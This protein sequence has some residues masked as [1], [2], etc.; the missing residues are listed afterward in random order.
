MTWG[1]L[2]GPTAFTW[3][4][5]LCFLALAAMGHLRG[6]F[7]PSVSFGPGVGMGALMLSLILD[8]LLAQSATLMFA[9]ILLRKSQSKN[10]I[11]SAVCQAMGLLVYFLISGLD[12]RIAG[13]NALFGTTGGTLLLVDWYGVTIDAIS[14]AVLSKLFF[15]SAAILGCYRLMREELQL[16]NRPWAWVAFLALLCGYIYGLLLPKCESC[17][18]SP[19]VILLISAVIFGVGAYAALFADRKAAQ[20]LGRFFTALLGRP[21]AAF[22]K[23]PL[24]LPVLLVAVAL[25]A[26]SAL[27]GLDD[28]VYLDGDP[29][30]LGGMVNDASRTF[31]LATLFLVLRDFGLV[32]GL[33]FGR[34]GARADLMALFW[35]A[36]LHL[37]LPSV[38]QVLGATF[39]A[40]MFSPGIT[41]LSGEG[42]IGAAA[43]ALLGTV[44]A[45]WRWRS[46]QIRFQ[47]SLPSGVSI[48]GK[49]T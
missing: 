46:S 21:F 36:I 4:A 39:L 41:A 34:K 2:F 10:R 48:S 28:R 31:I 33:A 5:G 19:S 30:W 12:S 29:F 49:A 6:G 16:T 7:E 35:L 1:K 23:A 24:W 40:A 8:G 9:L 42:V 38:L 27:V 3:I 45:V 18:Q 32:L 22:A 26:A 15:A 13:L 17:A 20:E 44:W 25:G 47:A 14:F 37:M 43:Q 11:A